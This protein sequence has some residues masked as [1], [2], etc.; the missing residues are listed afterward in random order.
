MHEEI[1]RLTSNF[2]PP[3]EK[4]PGTTRAASQRDKAALGA[5]VRARLG[6]GAHALHPRNALARAHTARTDG[7]GSARARSR[8]AR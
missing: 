3:S 6:V 7:E 1:F 4:S 5:G 8:R 2:G